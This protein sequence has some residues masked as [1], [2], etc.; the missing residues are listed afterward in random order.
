VPTFRAIA[1]EL[2]P[3]GATV[4][5]VDAEGGTDLIPLV[6]AGVPVLD[7]RQDAMTYFDFHHTANDTL[8]RISKDDLDQATAAF[9]VTAFAAADAPGDF[10]RIP[11][12]KRDRD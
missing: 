8:E 10:G 11:E 9:A 3:L 6:A 2:G 12:D 5:S 7:L 1:A 4:S